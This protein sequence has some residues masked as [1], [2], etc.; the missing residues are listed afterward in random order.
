MERFVTEMCGHVAAIES[1][2]VSCFTDLIDSHKPLSSHKVLS[3]RKTII[4]SSS[5]PWR[6]MSIKYILIYL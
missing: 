3:S 5:S 2:E 4:S 6:F 1:K